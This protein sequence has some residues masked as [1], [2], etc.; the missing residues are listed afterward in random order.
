M[1]GSGMHSS[2]RCKQQPHGDLAPVAV[3]S[4]SL[5]WVYH[6]NQQL[7]Q[8]RLGFL[9]SLFASFLQVLIRFAHVKLPLA[10]MSRKSGHAAPQELPALLNMLRGHGGISSLSLCNAYEAR[11]IT[12][13]EWYTPTGGNKCSFEL[14]L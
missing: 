8:R 10:V 3:R 11:R 12:I 4:D 13:H 14:L 9:P 5:H 1:Q 6:R 7:L 2:P